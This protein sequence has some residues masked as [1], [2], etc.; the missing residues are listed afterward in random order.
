MYVDYRPP[1]LQPWEERTRYSPSYSPG[2]TTIYGFPKKGG[3]YILQNAFLHGACYYGLEDFIK[4]E[5][6]KGVDVNLPGGCYESA[7]AAAIW[8]RRW[9]G[10][11]L[12][13][14]AE[15]LNIIKLLLD[16]G[17]NV[18][19]QGKMIR[20]AL[21]LS[22]VYGDTD[23]VQLILEYGAKPNGTGE[24]ETPIQVAC[25]TGMKAYLRY[26]SN[27]ALIPIWLPEMHA[28]IGLAFAQISR[29]YTQ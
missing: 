19:S 18:N 16:H 15:F 22:C 12:S 17:A 14:D 8:G 27:M 1:R 3:V 13:S 9:P 28:D 6:E 10:E 25:Y 23:V 20:S 11:L 2:S 26:F 29:I 4:V 7:L 21:W 5:L 24:E